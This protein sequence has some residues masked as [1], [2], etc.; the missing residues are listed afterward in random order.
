MTN[1][2]QTR[3]EITPSFDEAREEAFFENLGDYA[4]LT[5]GEGFDEFLMENLE[6][7]SKKLDEQDAEKQHKAASNRVVDFKHS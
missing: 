2:K 4:A 5:M 3:E 7:I 6:A 1:R